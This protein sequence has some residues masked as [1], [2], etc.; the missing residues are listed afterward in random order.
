MAPHGFIRQTP[1]DGRVPLLKPFGDEVEAVAYQVREVYV[2]ERERAAAG[3]LRHVER[4][5]REM[6]DA[7]LDEVNRGDGLAVA[8]HVSEHRDAEAYAPE[9]I[10]YLVRDLR[11]GLADGRER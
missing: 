11:G 2:G 8:R 6:F 1:L 5:L 4:E 7:A 10:L 3:E 9:R